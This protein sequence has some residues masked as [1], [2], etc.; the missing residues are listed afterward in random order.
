MFV[1]FLTTLVKTFRN[2]NKKRYERYFINYGR[3]YA[4]AFIKALTWLEEVPFDVE[5]EEAFENLRNT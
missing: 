3:A 4:E 5:V 1:V 2:K